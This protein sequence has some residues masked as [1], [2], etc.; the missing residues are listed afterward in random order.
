MGL[1]A[2]TFPALIVAN[3]GWLQYL[4]R[5]EELSEWTMSAIAKYS[6]QRVVLYDSSDRAWE[7]DSIDLVTP[8]SLLARL[9]NRKVPVRWSLRHLNEAPL[10][11]VRE[12][13]VEAIDADDDILT[14]SVSADD[15]KA[16]VQKASSFHTLI[17]TLKASHSI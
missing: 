10:Q 1:E 4:S 16:S 8:A 3:D 13:I 6:R 7:V 5:A 2:I 17:H 12:V 9:L 14:Q 11:V 15:L